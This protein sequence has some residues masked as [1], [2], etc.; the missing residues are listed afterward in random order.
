MSCYLIK[1]VEQYR[2]DTEAQA[3]A[4]INA[5]KE[6]G[7]YTVVKSSSEIKTTKSKGEVINEWRRVFIT[8]EFTSE[9]EPTEQIA[10][11]YEEV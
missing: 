9:K 5:A 10:I 1:V 6:D 8:K 11:S 3:E 2:C 7:Q 4:L